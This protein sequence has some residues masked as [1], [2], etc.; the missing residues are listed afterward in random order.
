M[1]ARLKLLFV[2]DEPSIVQGLRRMLNRMRGEWDMVFFTDPVEALENIHCDPPDVVVA[3]MRMPKMNGGQLLEAVRNQHPQIIRLILSGYSDV[4]HSVRT[5]GVAHQFL[6]K[7]CSPEILQATIRRIVQLEELMANKDLLRLVAGIDH[8]PTLPT[9]YLD[10]SKELS[11]ADPLID[12]IIEQIQTDPALTA[13]IL[14]LVNSG[15]FGLPRNVSDV[16]EASQLLGVG[17]LQSIVL[18]FGIHDQTTINGPLPISHHDFA[19]HAIRVGNLAKEI[20]R[21][22][23][24]P[25]SVQKEAF[26]AGLLHDMGT[27]VFSLCHRDAYRRVFEEAKSRKLSLS[28]LEQAVFGVDHGKLGSYLLHLWGLSST[29]AEA[30]AYHH[31]PSQ[32]DSD[33]IGCLAVVHLADVLSN[34]DSSPDQALTLDDFD[35]EYL[36]ATS[37]DRE[38]PQLESL[39]HNLSHA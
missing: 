33:E 38:L 14:Q 17:T 6:I 36:V 25:A 35:Q 3:D 9:L 19:L 31:S 7:P 8:L 12:R 13:K 2:D 24:L 26:T 21:M 22:L 27:L 5:I 20:S 28:Q 15:F 11:S 16:I 23:G 37:L 4:E 18:F 30:L 29:L 10:I 39:R 32:S 34:A 1:S